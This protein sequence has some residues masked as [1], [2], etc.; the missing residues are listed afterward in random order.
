MNAEL[1]RIAQTVYNRLQQ[2]GLKGRTI[3]LKIKYSDFKQIT[4]N[5]SFPYQVTEISIIKSTAKVLLAS[6]GQKTKKY[7]C[8]AFQFLISGNIT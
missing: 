1:D 3:T 7:V 6:T 5:Q 2:H 4:R 8:W